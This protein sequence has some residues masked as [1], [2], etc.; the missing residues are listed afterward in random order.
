M[1]KAPP[2]PWCTSSAVATTAAVSAETANHSPGAAR[3]KRETSESG[4]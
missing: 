2:L 4:L 3:L 1:S